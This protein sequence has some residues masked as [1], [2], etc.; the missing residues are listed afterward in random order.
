VNKNHKA[1]YLA[2]AVPSASDVINDNFQ[3]LIFFHG[4][5]GEDWPA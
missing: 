3:L 1:L 5:H 2:D 4:F